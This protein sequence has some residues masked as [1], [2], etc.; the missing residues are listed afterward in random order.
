MNEHA[1]EGA[2][3]AGYEFLDDVA[4]ADAAV[5]AWGPDPEAVFVQAA[6]ATIE[7]MLDDLTT[8]CARERREVS[9]HENDLEMLLFE[10]LQEQIYYKDSEELLLL[11]E[12]LRIER[13]PPW[14]LHATLAGETIDRHRHALNADV[15]AVTL[16]RFSLR[17]TDSGWEASVVLDI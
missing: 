5:R 8:L 16:H 4:I 12:R 17:P 7:L 13:G 9:L 2:A 10:L 14:Q 3:G 1:S 11:P 6:R 15:K